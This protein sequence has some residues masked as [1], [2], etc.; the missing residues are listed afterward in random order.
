[1][2]AVVSVTALAG[3]GAKEGV[4]TPAPGP[5]PVPPAESGTRL[6]L[7][8]RALRLLDALARHHADSAAHSL[9]VTTIL[10]AMWCQMPDPALDAEEVAAAGLLHDIGKLSL[11]LAILGGHTLLDAEQRAQ[12]ALHPAYGASLLRALGFP[13]AVVEAAEAHHERWDGTGYPSRLAGEQAPLAG[14]LVAVADSFVAMIEPG[15]PYRRPRT[16]IAALEEIARCAGTQFDPEAVRL[17]EAALG[18]PEAALFPA[19]ARRDRLSGD[20]ARVLAA[21][22]RAPWE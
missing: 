9:R 16:A 7:V 1:M 3:V 22:P 11:P 6:V 17:L 19:P 5:F 2:N 15:R 20:L 12:V 14:R 21:L 10:L 8:L 18:R 13:P 4:S